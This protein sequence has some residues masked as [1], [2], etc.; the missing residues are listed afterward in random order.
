MKNSNFLK[1]LL[2]AAGA[3][4]FFAII[5]LHITKQP[6]DDKQGVSFAIRR[7]SETKDAPQETAAISS[8]E[9]SVPQGEKTVDDKNDIDDGFDLADDLLS[10]DLYLETIQDFREKV[11]NTAKQRQELALDNSDDDTDDADHYDNRHRDNNTSALS[12]SVII[13]TDF[14]SD[15]DDVI[16]VRLAM[17]LQDAGMLDIK[18]IA[19]STTYSRSPLAIHALCYQDG[20]GSIPVAMDTSGNGVQVHTEYVDAMYDMPRSRSDYE[21][22]VE[23]YRRIL[24]ES[25]TKVNIITLGFLQNIHA[26]MN[27]KPDQYS[28]LTGMELISQKVDTLYITGGNSTG[29]PS[30]NFYWTGDKVI[31]AAHDVANDFPAR[32]VFLQSDLSDDT[33]CGQFYQTKDSKRNDIVT[34][35]LFAND[36]FDGIVA[37]DVFSVWCAAQDIN[38]N[39]DASFLELERG[40]QY[41]SSTGA[42]QWTA[43]AGGCHYKMYKHMQG[44]YYSQIMN[45][46]LLDKF[47]SY[48]S[49]V[50]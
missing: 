45:N 8:P 11:E 7:F 30:F 19:L 26:L 47:N 36:Q 24:S 37:W 6:E 12:K 44:A 40:K 17:C 39:L 1:L 2:T 14:A 13:D 38:D 27:S 22:P 31:N 5:F 15:S 43:D 28:P 23:L 4:C 32:I 35:A 50:P 18:G 48:F 20:Y 9:I 49:T 46:I 10:T 41:I 21:Q 29:K 3:L 34:K 25:D 42:T 33:F 16:A